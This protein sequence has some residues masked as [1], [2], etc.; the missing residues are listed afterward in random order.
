MNEG[1]NIAQ[2]PSAT[3]AA[4][5]RLNELDA[6]SE[7]SN[8]LLDRVDSGNWDGMLQLQ[9]ERDRALRECLRPPIQDGYTEAYKTKIQA[10]LRQNEILLQ[11]VDAA[12][13]FL[14]E[15]MRK[16]QQNHQAVSAYLA[17]GR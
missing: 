6:I 1:T 16:S 5:Q 14:L 4:E 13:T 3:R 2:F 17:S 15:E 10:L 9:T 12:K 8:A 7:L 11:Q